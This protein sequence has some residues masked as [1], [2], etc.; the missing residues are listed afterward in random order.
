[1]LRLARYAVLCGLAVLSLGTLE[2]CGGGGT[3]PVQDADVASS[4][5]VGPDDTADALEA[6]Q[7]GDDV[8]DILGKDQEGTDQEPEALPEGLCDGDCADLAEPAPEEVLDEAEAEAELPPCGDDCA[9]VEVEPDVPQDTEVELPP[10]CDAPDAAFLC[11]CQSD[12]DCADGY[13]VPTSDGQVCSKLCVSGCDAPGWVCAPF[14][15]QDATVDL[16]QW[17]NPLLCQPCA[18][19]NDCRVAG[20]ANGAVCVPSGSNGSFCGVACDVGAPCPA[21]YQC[22]AV[23]LGNGSSVDQCLPQEGECACSAASVEGGS[24]TPCYVQNPQGT[25]FGLR[26]CGPDGLSACDAATPAAEACNGQ[27]DDCDG[28]TDE[29]LSLAPCTI[30]NRF[31]ACPGQPACEDGVEVCHGTAPAE[32]E[33]NGADED[34]DGLTDEG[35]PDTDGDGQPDCIDPDDDDDGVLDDGDGSGVEGDSPCPAGQATGCDDNCQ[36]V[37]NLDQA[38][39]DADGLGDACDCDADNDQHQSATCGGTD[40]DDAAPEVNPGVAEGSASA[41]DC[42]WCNGLDDDCDGTTDEGCV[43]SDGDAL[44]DCIDPDD[45]NDGVPDAAD[46]CPLVPNGDQSDLDQDGL[47]DECDADLDNDGVLNDLD[48]C[49][50]DW[51]P[52]QEDHEGDGAGDV[53]DPDDD[54]DGVLDGNDNC[55][56]VANP[57]DPGSGLQPDADHDGIGDACDEDADGDGILDDGDGSGTP[58]DQP[59]KDAHTATCDDSCPTVP[60]P[61][62]LNQDNDGLGDACDDDADGDGFEA[63]AAGGDDCDD[64]DPTVNPGVVEGQQDATDCATCNG[65]DDDCDGSVDE[66]CLDSDGDGTLDCL[67]QDSDGD[68]VVDGKDNCP[69]VPNA[70]QEDLDH[71]GQGNA[72]DPDQDGD[73]TPADAGDCDDLDAAVGPGAAE[74]CNGKDDDCDGATDEGM[75]DLDVDG[76]PDC[77]DPDDDGDG[78]PDV[79]D[80]CPRNPNPGQTDLDGDGLGDACDPDKDGD[81]DPAATD[82]DDLDAT[83]RH[84]APEACNGKDDDCDG[85][86]DEAGSSGCSAF[87]RDAD[88]DTWG[89]AGDTRCLCAADVAGGYGATRGGDCND[90]DAQVNPGATE[91][92]NDKND[93]CVG[94][95]DEGCDADHDQYCGAAQVVVGTPAVCPLGGGDCN[96]RD[97]AVHPGAAEVCD[98]KDNNCAAGADEGCDDD[99][100]GYCDQALAMVGAPAACPKGGGDCDDQ[101]AQVHPGAPELC[102]GV[103]NDCDF[104]VDA[105]D[106]QDL[107]ASGPEPC[108]NQSG[109]CDG[110]TKPVALCVGGAWKPCLSAQYLD[111]AGAY[112]AGTEKACDGLDN[113]CD[114]STDEDFSVTLS[115]GTVVKGAGKPCST[116]TCGGGITVCRPDHD[117]IVCTQETGT[118]HEKCDGVDND[119]DN[120]TDAADASDLTTWDEQPCEKQAGVCEGAVKPTELCVGGAWQACTEAMYQQYNGLYQGGSELECDGLDNDCDGSADEDF[121][122]LMPDGTLVHGVGQAC[123]LGKCAGG[124]SQCLPSLW[125]IQCSTEVLA[126]PEVCNQLDDDCDGKTDGADPDLTVKDLQYCENQKGVCKGAIKPGTRCVG[127]GWL[128]CT[129]AEYQASSERY[130]FGT[131]ATCDGYD[132]DCDGAIDEDFS[133]TAPD[134]TQLFGVGK[135]CGLGVCAGGLTQCRPDKTGTV[136]SSASYAGPE[137]CDGLDNDCD[138]KTDADDPD[139]A[140]NDVR[141]CES[142]KGVCAGSRKT[143][144]LCVGGAWRPCT[145]A[146]YAAHSGD[147]TQGVELACDGLDND[148]SGVADEDFSLTLPSGTV[149]VGVGKTCDAAQCGSGETECKADGSGLQCSEASGPTPEVCDGKDNDCDGK[150]D[151]Q[152]PDLATNDLQ[153]CEKQDGACQGVTKPVSLCAGGAWQACTDAVYKAASADYDGTR[154]KRCDGKDNDCNGQA[155]ED[156]S[157]TT[158]DG[159]KV[160]GVGQACGVGACAGGLTQCTPAGD[161]IAC[162]TAGAAS[163]E[164]CNGADDDCDGATDGADPD[165]AVNDRRSCELQAGVC[166]GAAKPAALCVNGAWQACGDAEYLAHSAFFQGGLEAACDGRDNDCDSRTDEDFSYTDALGGTVSGVGQ[167]CGLGAC[168]GGQTVCN[169]LGSGVTCSTGH[170]ATAEACNGRDDDCDGL[171][172]A[173]DAAD[174]VAADARPCELAVGVCAGA[175]K[176]AGLCYGGTW[177]QC[178]APDYLAHAADYQEAVELACDGRDNDCNGQADEDFALKLLDGTLVTGVGRTCGTGACGTSLTECLPDGTGIRCGAESGVTPE[179]CDGFDN[180]CDGK[181][182]AADPDLL[183]HDTRLCENQKGACGGATKPA[184]LCQSGNWVPCSNSTYAAASPDFQAAAETRCDGKDNDCDGGTDEDFSVKLKDGVTVFGVGQACGVGVCAG[185]VTACNAAGSGITCPTEA[186]AGPERCNGV[187]DDCDGKTDLQDAADLAANDQPPCEKQ[188][189]ACLGARKPSALCDNGAWLACGPSVYLAHNPDYNADVE[190]YC[191]TL[192]NDCDGTADED[193]SF[194]GGNGQPVEG[195]GAACG[196]GLCAGGTSVCK[197]DNSGTTCSTASQAQA[198]VCDTLDNDCDG[199]ADAADAADL[200]A[201]DPQMC[202]RQGGVCA[203]ATKLADR[204]MGGA[205]VP[206]DAASYLARSPLYNDGAEQLCDGK[207]NDCDGATDEDFTLL[208]PDGRTVQGVGKPCGTG[209]CGGGVTQCRPDHSGIQCTTDTGATPELCNGVDD[210]CDGLTDAQDPGLSDSDGQACENQMGVCSGSRKPVA[211]CQGGVWQPCTAA[212]YAGWS[213]YYQNNKELSCDG[214][215]NDCNGQTDEDFTVTLLNGQTVTGAGKACGVGLCGGGLTQCKPDLAGIV[216]S[217]ESGARPEKCNGQDDDCDGKVDAQDATDLA[218]NDRTACELQ[219]GVCA[220]SFK[221]VSLCVAGKW[222]ACTDTQ[223]LANNPAYQPAVELSCDGA[224][225]DCNG[226]TDEDFT[227]VTLAGDTIQGAGKN[228]GT[229]RCGGGVTQCNPG[230]NGIVCSTESLALPETCNG[231]DDDCDSR[232]D[233]A[234]A[235]D[236]A[237]Y[238]H[239]SCERQAGLCLGSAKPGRLCLGGNWLPCDDQAYHDNNA[240]YEGGVELSCDNRD[241]DCDGKSDEDFV[242][243]MP[244]GAAVVGTGKACGVGQCAGGLTICALGGDSA[245]CSTITAVQP[246]ACDNLDND[247]D[248]KTDS[249]DPADLV[250]NDPQSCE[251]QMGVCAGSVKPAA[252]CVGGSWRPCDAAAYGLVTPYFEA[253]QEVQCDGLDNDCNGLTDEDFSVVLKNGQTVTGINK[254]CGVGV[255]AGG[256]TACTADSLGL[257][258]PSELNATGERCNNLDDDCDGAT[259]T[260]DPL[261]LAANDH[262]A[263]EKQAGVCAGASKPTWLCEGGAWK[264]CPD[265]LY[266]SHH[267]AYQ[268][269]AETR[270]D[271]LDN[272]CSGALDEDFSMTTLSGARVNGVGQACGAGACAGGVTVCDGAG[273]GLLCDSETRASAEKCNGMDDDCDGKLD[274]ADAQDLLNNDLRACE[275]QAGVC[276]GA[277][278]P[279]DLCYGGHWNPCATWTY[280][281]KSSLYQDGA[282][283]TCDAQDNDCDGATDEDFSL[284]LLTG[285]VVSGVGALCGSGRCAG[286]V[287]RCANGGRAIECPTESLATFERCNNVDDDCDGLTDAA[288]AADLMANESVPCE[289]QAGLCQGAMKT[290][291][292]CQAGAWV[293]CNGAAYL[294]HDAAYE[295]D[296]EVRCDGK[297][298]DCNGVTDEDFAIVFKDGSSATAP[299]VACGTGRCVGGRTQCKPDQLGLWCPTEALATGEKCNNV[300]DDCDGLTDTADVAD[301]MANDTQACEKQAGICAGTTKPDWLCQSGT[302]APCPAT[303]YQAHDSRYNAGAEALCDGID[304]NCSGDADEQFTMQQLDGTVQVGT[305]KPCG[306]GACAGGV[307]TCDLAGS[308]IYCPT[309]SR[310]SSEVCNGLDDD[311][312][313]TTDA[314]DTSDLISGFLRYDQPECA[315]QFGVCSGSKKPAVLCVGGVW[316]ACTDAVYRAYNAIY[317]APAETS[318]DGIDNDCDGT[319]DDDFTM[320]TKDGL[321]KKGVNVNCGAGVCAGGKTA[322][323]QAANGIYCITESLAGNESCNGLDDDCDAKTDA[324]DPTLSRPACEKQA[325]VCAGSMKPAARCVAGVWQDCATADYLATAPAYEAGAEVYCDALDNDCDASTDEDFTLTLKDGQ[326]RTLPGQACGAGACTGGIVACRADQLGLT[327]PTEAQSSAEVCDGVDND[328][329]STLDASDA[330]DLLANDRRD[331][332]LQLGV[333]AGATKPASLCSGGQWQA[334]TGGTYLS[335]NAAYKAGAEDQCDGLDNNCDG[336]YDDAFQVTMPDGAVLTGTGLACGV[337]AC[338]GGHTVCGTDHQSITCDTLSLRT[339]EVCDGVDNDCDG[340][341]D[342]ADPDLAN[343]DRQACEMQQ[344]VC[345]G[346]SKPVSLCVSGQWQ[347]CTTAHYVAHDARYQAGAEAT[348]D[349]VDNDCNGSPDEDFSYT[350]W[351]GQVVWGTGAACGT[352]GCV[353]GV[354]ICKSDQRG[355]KCSSEAGTAPETC[356]GLDDDCDGL[357]DAADPDLAATDHPAC[358]LQQGVCAGSTKPVSLCYGATWHP[359]DAAAYAANSQWYDAGQELRCDGRD[360]DCDG[361]ADEDFSLVLKNGQTVTGPGKTCG[362]GVC[363]GGVTLCNAEGTGIACNKEA[364]AQPE[365]CDNLDNDCD[366][367][368][369]LNDPDLGLNT[370]CELTQGVCAGSTKPAYLCQGGVWNACGPSEYAMH[371]P[372]YNPGSETSCDDADNNCNGTADEGFSVTLLDGSVIQGTG[373]VCGAGAC[374]GGTTVC[375]PDKSGTYCT[376]EDNVSPEVCNGTDDDCDGKLDTLDPGLGANDHPACEKQ[377]SLCQGATKPARLC[378]S[379]HWE[380]CDDQAYAA[381]NGGYESPERSCDG[382]DNDCDGAPDEDFSVTMPNGTVWGVGQ[383]CGVGDCAGGITSCNRTMNGIECSTAG[384][385]NSE[386]CDNRDNDCDGKT[387]ATDPDLLTSDL[388]LCGNQNGVCGGSTRPASLCVGGAWQ[389][390]GQAHYAAHSQWFEAGAEVLCDGRDNDCDGSADEDASMLQRNGVRVTG[391]GTNCGVGVCTGTS[392]VCSQDQLGLACPGESAATGELCDALDNDCDGSRDED[393]TYTGP[394]GSQVTGSEKPCGVGAC[395]GGTTRCNAQKTGL[396]CTTGGQVTQET[397]DNQDNDCDGLTDVADPDLASNPPFCE[398]QQGVCAG[399]RKDVTLCAGGAWAAC[400]TPVYRAHDARYDVDETWCDGV[401]NNCDGQADDS[402]GFVDSLCVE[403][404]GGGAHGTFQCTRGVATPDPY[405]PYEG[406]ESDGWACLLKGCEANWTDFN[407]NVTD[408]CECQALDPS[409]FALDGTIDLPPQCTG[410]MDLGTLADGGAGASVTVTGRLLNTGDVDWYKVVFTDGAEGEQNSFSAVV[411]LDQDAGGTAE[412]AVYD[413]KVMGLAGCADIDNPVVI[414]TCQMTGAADEWGWSVKGQVPGSKGEYPCNIDVGV[415]PNPAA[416]DCSSECCTRAPLANV[417]TIEHL[418]KGLPEEDDYVTST[419][420]NDTDEA[421][422]PCAIQTYAQNRAYCNH[423]AGKNDVNYGR[424]VYVRVRSKGTAVSCTPYSLTIGNNTVESG[425]GF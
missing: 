25:C 184:A 34:C 316:Q 372:D 190:R 390:C 380:P 43:D 247:C 170:V 11:P 68:G 112:Q 369:D 421:C 214:R 3:P 209:A 125:G 139:L 412:V 393:F 182:D 193:F 145:A 211:L 244:D 62:Q 204:C 174:L 340:L 317:Q 262:P 131:E 371:D 411:H 18:Q 255:C 179:V 120:L 74:A 228:C 423:D 405:V 94:G 39:F 243:T 265:S 48:N 339:L 403:P 111:H 167:A 327:C 129:T 249:A 114:G 425:H 407:L 119:C 36:F 151:S 1:M 24:A 222:N 406:A 64:L 60:N 344:G 280:L 205:W 291:S 415:C 35:F 266:L 212:T 124:T 80:N 306:A 401:D 248:G 157:L 355:L 56:L 358:E 136:C 374:A 402:A 345:S 283:T 63:V 225:N 330:A 164:L 245:V 177:H 155:D 239:Q 93:N 348:C 83:V 389:E 175:M 334:C 55:P 28:V 146:Q 354:T 252:Y 38:D 89:V 319:R 171:T 294:A 408:G 219:Q 267:A 254:D 27:D 217:S 69:L 109:V 201:N 359:C 285:E 180:D 195:V 328:C 61:D 365:T 367:R 277:N 107:L 14:V 305:G 84:G 126:G 99:G 268:P 392:T 156:F 8:P 32:E 198:E 370:P 202:E 338:A 15:G 238:D 241:N 187:D 221:P 351:N 128:P 19:D 418:Y 82:C 134:G 270:C 47:G 284:T 50:A 373:K 312:D 341:T 234:D 57:A 13:C 300:D 259:D 5:E 66:G 400:T 65:R 258:C 424:M 10:S 76:L 176:P 105:N 117:G 388:R 333:C 224:D 377:A 353:G 422:N 387:D 26:R 92:C 310:A 272:D 41:L 153:Q 135:A 382:R 138:G 70:G 9:E 240:L 311:C 261:D 250:A 97:A 200:T 161:A 236:L 279:A 307:T 378:V 235:T 260:Q 186:N 169:P 362:V 342:G 404:Y 251:N 166:N 158:P 410:A 88:G 203:G 191:D 356:N 192:D 52:A 159:Q 364:L 368:T 322:C 360:N 379:G 264:P 269:L 181:T 102:D 329:D 206:C 160:T 302:W 86:V 44:P 397:C 54:N 31:G 286:G 137:V 113:D 140:T 148:C 271:G 230:H 46:N 165:T 162:S 335:H 363:V 67:S 287:T 16:C 141:L 142:Q 323:N 352:G 189:G 98:G 276:A 17:A 220:G 293:P 110:A 273:T 288:D 208:L 391:V 42:T 12:D 152:D 256:K 385:I 118:S 282:E 59:C 296:Q 299:G 23:D 163:L 22:V 290:A 85:S 226:E 4:E 116:G 127:G 172:D 336:K 231:Q 349:G 381:F 413:L 384:N 350:L 295:A 154:E 77:T 106:A 168:A 242:V 40:C 178:G 417:D 320:V 72:C 108:E 81:Q 147:F 325:G 73:G 297:D 183:D 33:C 75:P 237:N 292:Q 420:I 173:D 210:D 383:G 375:K 132:N 101:D 314:A 207:D 278:K 87:F 6:D 199:L 227:L 45:D 215:D 37:K 318:C 196:V 223:Y 386:K 303:V 149:L 289:N 399:T 130:Q 96:D 71:D 95:V 185:G 419:E 188:A 58:G 301:L 103:D 394:D 104:Q 357:T 343:V 309:E 263:C 121:T 29:G 218:A 281:Q 229:G 346:A 414:P 376:G 274:A 396:F 79:S 331:C 313:G 2:S 100:D 78:V 21:G 324:A 253:N 133:T 123:G 361:Q 7:A 150:T 332:E 409:A 304:N 122:R 326:V 315:K 347:P 213:Q 298:N 232:T 233:A 246:E 275:K 398:K 216:C 366:G 30:E 91:I 416:D 337:G 51:N 194:T 115:N 321:T 143:A 144:E 20:Q 90:G 49:P 53:C 257:R 308:G 395:A 197:L